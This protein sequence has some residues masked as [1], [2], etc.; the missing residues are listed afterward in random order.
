[1]KECDKI[2]KCHV[3]THKD[4]CTRKAMLPFTWI[5]VIT[6]LFTSRNYHPHQMPR[7]TQTQAT[8][9]LFICQSPRPRPAE[10]EEDGGE[11][12]GR[13]LAGV[14]VPTTRAQF[15]FINSDELR[16]GFGGGRPAS[17]W[18]WR[19]GGLGSWRR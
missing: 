8:G 16:R 7:L 15:F 1:M 14:R 11:D 4:I 9:I 2:I 10:E 6:M 18:G 3:N 5:Y 17:R 13:D 12:G 19:E